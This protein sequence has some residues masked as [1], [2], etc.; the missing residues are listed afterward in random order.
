MLLTGITI[1]FA[2]SQ[3]NVFNAKE[4]VLRNQTCRFRFN[5]SNLILSSFVIGTR[6]QVAR[7]LLCKKAG[8]YYFLCVRAYIVV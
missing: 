2:I 1:V 7:G 4:H 8:G 5:N 6:W 3:R